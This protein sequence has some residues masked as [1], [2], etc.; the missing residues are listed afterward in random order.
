MGFDTIEINLVPARFAIQKARLL[1]LK[2]ILEEKPESV[3]HRFLNLQLLNPT[4]GDWAST[5]QQYLKELEINLSMKEIMILT[6]SKLTKI[7]K[8]AI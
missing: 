6:K 1:F 3:I 4:K 8:K 2:S 5:C 7:I